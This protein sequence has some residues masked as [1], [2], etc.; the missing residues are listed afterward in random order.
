MLSKKCFKEDKLCVFVYGIEISISTI[1]S[2]LLVTLVSIFALNIIQGLIFFSCFSSLRLFSGG[3]HSNTYFRCNLLFTLICSLCLIVTK[4]VSLI[5]I[6]I[7]T[8]LL[9]FL[10]LFIGFALFAPIQNNNK[11]IATNSVF[12]QKIKTLVILT[13]HSLLAIILFLI[14][15]DY[16]VCVIV[17]DVCVFLL[18]LVSIILRKKEGKLC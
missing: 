10:L 15:K 17:T 13:I 3:Y 14:K 1:M 18:V 11:K 12:K 5:E 16:A 4:V 2:I 9:S 6:T 8:I 7:P